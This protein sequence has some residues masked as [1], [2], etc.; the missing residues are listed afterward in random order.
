MTNLFRTG[1]IVAAQ[2]LGATVASS[3]FAE[4]AT[5][6]TEAIGGPPRGWLLTMTGKGAPK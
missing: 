6:E 5:S 3:A 2:L 4:T 1:L